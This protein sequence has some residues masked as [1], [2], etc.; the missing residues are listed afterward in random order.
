M[1]QKIKWMNFK[2]DKRSLV[3]REQ[4]FIDDD[5]RKNARIHIAMISN[6]A[7]LLDELTQIVQ[8]ILLKYDK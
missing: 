4:L 3:L 1:F 2:D 6:T 7:G 8:K 5:I